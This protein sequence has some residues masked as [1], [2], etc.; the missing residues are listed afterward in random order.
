MTVLF[1]S[2][3]RIGE[4][5]SGTW[6]TNLSV[7]TCSNHD[8]IFLGIVYI[9]FEL[10]LQHRSVHHWELAMYF[11]KFSNKHLFPLHG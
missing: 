7:S 11:F 5:E 10:Q 6:K 9:L 2:S 4:Q 1:P 3:L 8:I